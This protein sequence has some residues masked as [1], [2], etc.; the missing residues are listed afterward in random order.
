M[1]EG[2]II[3]TAMKWLR[4]IKVA[5]DSKSEKQNKT[6]THLDLNV[7]VDFF[8]LKLYMN[9]ANVTCMSSIFRTPTPPLKQVY[10]Q[11]AVIFNFIHHGYLEI[12]IIRR[13]I[14]GMYHL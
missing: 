7:S 3:L 10:I 8:Y 4:C 11:Y 6:R 1:F 13:L 5:F 12:E 9:T 2:N 14:G